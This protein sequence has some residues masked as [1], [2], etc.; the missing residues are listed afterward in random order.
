MKE[1][2]IK[3]IGSKNL[4]YD[5]TTKQYKSTMHCPHCGKY[6]GCWCYPDF[7]GTPTFDEEY[8]NVYC[9]DRH[10][11]LG[12]SDNIR[13]FAN[14]MGITIK[15][16]MEEWNASKIVRVFMEDADA[17]CEVSGSSCES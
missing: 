11:V 10:F 12:E 3:I 16:T 15:P 6:S 4:Y 7:E 13:D 5:S 8:P 9:S 17:D 14:E 2:I 1:G